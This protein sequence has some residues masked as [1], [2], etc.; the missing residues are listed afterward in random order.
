M[1]V[2]EGQ[3]RRVEGDATGERLGPV[4]R[5]DDPAAAG[6]TRGLGLL[7]AEH[8]V[9]GEPGG[10][11]F[12]DE[13][14][15]VPIGGGDRRAVG[16]AVDGE[17]AGL[18]PAQGRLAGLAGDVDGEVEQRP[19]DRGRGGGGVGGGGHAVMVTEAVREAH[20]TDMS[21]EPGVIGAVLPT[22][23]DGVGPG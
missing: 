18:E 3:Q 22:D 1:L 23:A 11:P 21:T 20:T 14:L 5:V 13:A 19:V 15:G 4:D 12:P 8:A 10:D 2:V 7:L 16:L 9:V 17:V 6:G